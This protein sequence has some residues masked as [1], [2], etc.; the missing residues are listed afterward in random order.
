MTSRHD[1]VTPLAFYG[2]LSSIRE[3]LKL[4]QEHSP[5]PGGAALKNWPLANGDIVIL[6]TCLPLVIPKNRSIM[7]G[8]TASWLSELQA[9]TPGKALSIVV[10]RHQ[11]AFH[12]L[13]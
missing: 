9:C 10:S 7:G 4:G 6:T 12:L 2:G 3:T 5:I 11:S 13:V 1:S 8:S